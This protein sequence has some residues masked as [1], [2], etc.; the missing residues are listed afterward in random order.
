MNLKNVIPEN[1]LEKLVLIFIII[2]YLLFPIGSFS[3]GISPVRGEDLPVI[4]NA[5]KIRLHVNDKTN[6]EPVILASVYVNDSLYESSMTNLDGV[7]QSYPLTP[8]K[9]NL[10]IEAK[11]YDNLILDSINV[12]ANR[13]FVDTIFMEQVA[14]LIDSIHAPKCD[15]S[16]FKISSREAMK[17]ALENEPKVGSINTCQIQ[18]L[19][20]K[21]VWFV[22]GKK[23][24]TTYYIWYIDMDTG[25]IRKKKKYNDGRVGK[26]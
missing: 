16:N 5:G 22:S 21:C 2:F 8:G 18:I 1:K 10:R 20:E 6:G 3:Q 19:N 9:Y 14:V 26:F 17:I 4:P 12:I 24:I 15:S 23:S 11:K 13:I 7:W 25:K